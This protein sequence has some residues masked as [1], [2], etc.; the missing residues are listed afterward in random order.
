MGFRKGSCLSLTPGVEGSRKEGQPAEVSVD[1]WGARVGPGEPHDALG[2][3]ESPGSPRQAKG[4]EGWGQ[5]LEK[6]AAPLEGQQGPS[7]P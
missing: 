4:Q 7:R 5:P 6:N 2:Q 1:R 3:D